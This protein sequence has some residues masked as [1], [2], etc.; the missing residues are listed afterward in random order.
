MMVSEALNVDSIFA[1]E[2]PQ[3]ARRSCRQLTKSNSV[4]KLELLLGMVH[5]VEARYICQEV[6]QK[7]GFEALNVDSI[8]ANELPECPPVLA[9]C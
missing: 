4:L 3:N 6:L 8:F 7:M 9:G 5:I 1:N 2:Y